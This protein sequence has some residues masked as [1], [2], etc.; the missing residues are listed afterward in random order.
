MGKYR[1]D[2][3]AEADPQKRDDLYKNFM[4]DMR[5]IENAAS[6]RK[7]ELEKLAKMQNNA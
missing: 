6:D 4:K 1:S 3:E 2:Y 5:Q 7:K